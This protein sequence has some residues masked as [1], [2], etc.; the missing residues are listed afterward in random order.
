M[1]QG[2]EGKREGAVDSSQMENS[3]LFIVKRFS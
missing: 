3:L 2:P 1:V